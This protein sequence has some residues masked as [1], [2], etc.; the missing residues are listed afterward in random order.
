VVILCMLIAGLLTACG[1]DQATTSQTPVGSAQGGN[2]A[3]PSATTGSDAGA[4]ST[5]IP[6]QG[7]GAERP[8]GI[9]LSK[10]DPCALLT[11]EETEAIVGP[12]DW[13]AAPARDN[14]PTVGLSCYYDEWGRGGTPEKSLVVR[15]VA[16][17]MV[18][19]E[20]GGELEREAMSLI[21][22]QEVGLGSE[23]VVRY[24]DTHFVTLSLPK[25]KGEFPCVIAGEGGEWFRLTAI[26]PDTSALRI[27][28]DPQNLDH[29]KQL[30]R[31][32]LE[33]LVIE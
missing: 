13:K 8:R 4:S 14:D 25:C 29:A 10:V 2:T 20:F 31:K 3:Q 11:E 6:Q 21:P 15:L 32:I 18:V 7:N 22:P 24:D 26:M 9:D 17:K 23:I 1:G 5:T 33:R 30:A 16:P 19:V 28:L 27:E 12:L